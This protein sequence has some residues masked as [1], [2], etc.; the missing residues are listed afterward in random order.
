VSGTPDFVVEADGGSRGNP[1]PAAFGS[2]VRDA[3]TGDVVREVAEALGTTTNNVAEYRGL[4]AGLEAVHA[5]DP[6]ARVEARLDSKLVVEQM[7]GRWKIKHENLRELALRARRAHPAELITYTWVPREQNRAAD[8]LVNA[9]LDGRWTGSSPASSPMA[10]STDRSAPAGSPAPG[11]LPGW[12]PAPG[13]TT[14]TVL[15]RHGHTRHSVEKRFSG[16]GGDDPPLNERGFTE[17]A[18]AARV[19]GAGQWDVVVASPMLRTRQT[20]QPLA[21]HLGVDLVIA[22]GLA[23]CSFGDW[24]G[25]TFDDVAQSWPA[26]LDRWLSSTAVAPP[27]GE[28]FDDVARRVA[29]TR[30][31]LLAQYVGRRLVLVSHVTPIKCLVGQALAAPVSVLFRMELAPASLTTLRW[32]DDGSASMVGFNDTSH[33]AQLAGD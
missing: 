12:S 10:P 15:L 17:A 16:L 18:A 32:Y 24:D 27:G 20:A 19:L 21:D 26:E 28:S 9:V 11:T 33:L 22:D 1:G 3:R 25:R 29:E 13:Q 4:I 14:T 2:V 23:E 30:Q 31:T 6:E 8:A 5:L 7:S